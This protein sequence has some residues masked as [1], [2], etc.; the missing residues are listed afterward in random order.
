M[1][2]NGWNSGKKGATVHEIR[3]ERLR[4]SL[5]GPD[6]KATHRHTHRVWLW[7]HILTR[8]TVPQDDDCRRV[9]SDVTTHVSLSAEGWGKSRNSFWNEHGRRNAWGYWLGPG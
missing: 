4:S 9:K 3:L 6:C 5:S 2:A 7:L 8:S 1:G